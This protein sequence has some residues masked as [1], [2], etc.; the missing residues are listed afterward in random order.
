MWE[1]EVLRISVSFE[2][3]A[4]RASRSCWLKRRSTS[5]FS[6][7]C[8]M[9]SAVSRRRVCSVLAMKSSGRTMRSDASSRLLA[10][11]RSCRGSPQLARCM[12]LIGNVARMPCREEGEDRRRATTQPYHS[13]NNRFENQDFCRIK[14]E[15]LHSCHFLRGHQR[16]CIDDENAPLCLLSQHYSASSKLLLL[17]S[18]TRPQPG[19]TGTG[20]QKP[21]QSYVMLPIWMC[22]S[23][24]GH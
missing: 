8:F 20:G 10:D 4:K 24:S 22:D 15:G 19:S 16:P 9:A 2:S 3:R 6:S 5:R 14:A 13:A 7:A 17:K 18:L 1:A 21:S 11:S 12:D 23:L